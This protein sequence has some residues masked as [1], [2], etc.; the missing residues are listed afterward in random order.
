MPFKFLI[1]L[2]REG[3]AGTGS[4]KGIAEKLANSF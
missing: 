4:W 2:F 1:N 3:E